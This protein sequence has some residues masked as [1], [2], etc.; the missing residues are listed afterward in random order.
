MNKLLLL[1]LVFCI[2]VLIQSCAVTPVPVKRQDPLISALIDT[3]TSEPIEFDALMERISTRI[4][5]DV[6]GV[7]RVVYDVTQKPPATIEYE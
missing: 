4:S 6:R 5:N 1:S 3:R 7:N 2:P